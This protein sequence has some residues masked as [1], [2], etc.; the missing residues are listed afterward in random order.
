MTKVSA[1]IPCFNSQK[2]ILFTL[3]SIDWADEIFVCDSYST[4]STLEI[5]KRYRAGIIQHEYVN[6]AR[7][8]NW[9]IPQCK[10]EWV[11]IVDTD[12]ILE[13]GTK[14]ELLQALHNVSPEVDGFRIPRKNFIYGKW[15]RH[16]GI[17][18]D[19]Q[20]RLFRKDK[21]C[22]EDREVHAHLFVPGKVKVLSHHLIHNG[23]KDLKT[24]LIK[25]HRY[26]KYEVDELH[27]RKGKLCSTRLTIYPIFLFFKHYLGEFGF[28]EGY[29]GFMLAVLSAFYYF[30]VHARLR[31]SD[32][33][34]K[35]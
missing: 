29:R 15:L 11:L 27:K 6:S 18:P 16:G 35:T 13:K 3:Q 17:Y 25:N 9:A 8:K 1:L 26:V 10:N 32:I 24:W 20:L 12:E 7:Q 22:Y 28:L 5:A 30:L 2:T 31:E 4:D 14:E 33:L 23:F 19:Y 21:G 34:E